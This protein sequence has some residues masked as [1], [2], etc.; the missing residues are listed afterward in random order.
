[1]KNNIPDLVFTTIEIETVFENKKYTASFKYIKYFLI[2]FPIRSSKY[3]FEC[4]CVSSNVWVFAE[5]GLPDTIT[6]LPAA[7]GDLET[8]KVD[9]LEGYSLV[10]DT[11]IAKIH[12][13]NTDTAL[14]EGGEWYVTAE[15]VKT[16]Y[17]LAHDKNGDEYLSFNMENEVSAAELR[18][19]VDFANIATPPN[20]YQIPVVQDITGVKSLKYSADFVFENGCLKI[21]GA[22]NTT[23]K[24][25]SI[26]NLA[27]DEKLTILDSGLATF[28]NRV[29]Q[30]GLGE[31][32]FSV[33]KLD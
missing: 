12:R 16:M 28:T 14:D 17:S 19:V 26:F 4:F 7:V 11:E 9:K 31:S 15:E 22:G 24:S 13:K 6:T 3:I 33:L 23:G 30:S 32:T 18:G 2:L 29:Y 1:M 27:G 21:K 10:S 5:M 20:A 25:L 8:G